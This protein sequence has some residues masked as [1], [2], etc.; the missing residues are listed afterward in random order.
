MYPCTFS[1]LLVVIIPGYFPEQC[2]Q[3]GLY[4]CSWLEV[5]S[6]Q[7]IRFKLEHVVMSAAVTVVQIWATGATVLSASWQACSRTYRNAFDRLGY[8]HSSL[9]QLQKLAQ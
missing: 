5:C 3:H 2:L 1:N 7:M 6:Y 8:T 9:S 4:S